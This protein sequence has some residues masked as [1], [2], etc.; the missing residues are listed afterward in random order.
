MRCGPDHHT[1]NVFET[2]PHGLA[3]FA[4]EVKDFAELQRACDVLVT[5]TSSSNGAEP[6]RHR[7]T[8]LAIT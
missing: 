7:T 1:I 5:M 3:H 2:K 8:S 4:F 6:A